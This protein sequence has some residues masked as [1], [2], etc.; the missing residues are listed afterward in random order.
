LSEQECNF[1]IHSGAAELLD[2]VG[3]LWRQLRDHHA[4]RSTD[5]SDDFAA[6]DFSQRSASLKNKGVKLRVDLLSHAGRDV[7]YCVSTIDQS[8]TG[9]ID[10]L[11]VEE[12][13]RRQGH[14]R[15]LAE[16]ALAWMDENA[17]ERRTIMVAAG[18]EEAIEFYRRLGFLPRN[19]HLVQKR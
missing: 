17:V 14:G 16:F 2:R 10:S 5:W 9:E 13:Y 6:A 12:S 15:R 7:A 4:S 11:F 8:G 18:N 1:E 3:T 19:V